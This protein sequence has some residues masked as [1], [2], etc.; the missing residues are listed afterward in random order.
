MND[1][2]KK[3]R[4]LF[5][6]WLN[7][8]RLQ[9]ENR[10]YSKIF[11]NQAL[12]IPTESDLSHKFFTLFPNSISRK[13][14]D[15]S[16]L[17]IY[18]HYNWENE[19]LLPSLA[20]FGHVIHYDWFGEFNHYDEK[21][22]HKNNKKKM[23][24]VLVEKVK[25]WIKQYEIDVIFTYISGEIIY[26]STI[27]AIASLGIPVIN[28]SL[29]DKEA[30]VGKIRGGMA[31]GMRDICKYFHLCWTSTKDSLIKYVVEGASPFYLPEGANPEKHRPYIVGQDVDVSFVGQCY[32]DRPVIIE[33]L[34]NLGIHVEAFGVGWPNGPLAFEEMVKLYSRSKINLG[35]GKV[36]GLRDVFCL[37]GRDFEVPMSGGFYLTAFNEELVDFFEDGREI[38]TYKSFD[39]LVLKIKYYLEHDYEREVIRQRGHLR[40]K[41]DHTWEKR[42]E[43]IFSIIGI[44]DFGVELPL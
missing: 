8:R 44:L 15:L 40:A 26:P 5:R 34:R 42:F 28:M 29:N 30:F 27:K 18:H 12:N 32:G 39:D 19:S 23:N 4:R 21:K 41:N 9:Q 33:K 3:Y 38:V 2:L 1:P 11:N 31:M 22:W 35:F 14:G 6:Q 13:K 25:K 20:K 7:S 37:K 10:Y 43:K 36:D 16:I 24:I 17:A